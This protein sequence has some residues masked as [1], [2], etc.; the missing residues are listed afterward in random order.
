[1]FIEAK[2]LK[3]ITKEDTNERIGY[4]NLRKLLENGILITPLT[5]VSTKTTQTLLDLYGIDMVAANSTFYKTFAEREQKSWGEVVFDRLL[6]YSTTYGGLSSFLGGIYEPTILD[7]E[8]H[9]IVTNQFTKIEVAEKEDIKDRLQALIDQ[10]IALPSEDVPIL[11]ETLIDYTID[12][13]RSKNREVVV[14]YAKVAGI[15]M[16]DPEL[17][18]RLIANI[19]TE[20]TSFVKSKKFYDLVEFRLMSKGSDIEHL[21]K[22]YVYR[23][24]FEPLATQFRSHK[25]FWLIIRKY[26]AKREINR[27]KRLSEQ[28][29]EPKLMKTIFDKTVEEFT[30]DSKQMSVYQLVRSWNYL[31]EQA[32]LSHEV[33][34][35][36]VYRIR[37]GRAWFKTL[38]DQDEKDVFSYQY[39]IMNELKNRFAGKDMRVYLP[40]EH[41]DIKMPTSAKSFIGS[42]P[43]YT[44]I[45]VEDDYQVGVYWQST[46]DIDL[47]AQTIDGLH[48]GWYSED[49]ESV[50]YTGDMTSCNSHGYAAEAMLIKNKPGIT[51][52]IQPYR[53]QLGEKC[54]IYIA[55]S[56][57]KN[58]TQIVQSRQLL[59]Q[60]ATHGD[61]AMTFASSLPGKV[62]LTNFQVGGQ[63][64]DEDAGQKL[65]QVI[66]RK[67]STAM[68]LKDF[69]RII[70]GQIVTNSQ[71]ATYD[72]SSE[73]ISLDTWVDFLEQGA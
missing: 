30:K 6:H 49:S 70:N 36:Q 68:T 22:E 37:N 40:D 31:T 42:Y 2:Y 47:H 72:F 48:I 15:P 55:N 60:T 69:I 44:T 57:D 23:Y 66:E 21:I 29:H 20:D 56:V 39:V 52:S 9:T 12:G 53:T 35:L 4:N 13:S 65:A 26:A 24:G 16:R 45:A 46:S 3:M 34:P 7:D 63:L 54:K 5:P 19:L 73:A 64:P 10:A 67:S 59:F 61:H 71:E 27:I 1:M 18:V 62:V 50:V 43:M 38:A 32:A 33:S 17:F 28:L 58:A 14:Q 8:L 41:V 25:R 51:F 11:V